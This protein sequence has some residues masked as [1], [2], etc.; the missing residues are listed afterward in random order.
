MDPQLKF[1]KGCC[2]SE[3]AVRENNQFKASF[4]PTRS[5]PPKVRF[6]MSAIPCIHEEEDEKKHHFP[7]FAMYDNFIQDVQWFTIYN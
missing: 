6:K 2:I 1:I 4:L 7:N 3:P 5:Q